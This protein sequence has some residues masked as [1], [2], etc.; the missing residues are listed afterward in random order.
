MISIIPITGLPEV[1]A[2]D[3]L[4][5]VITDGIER[6]EVTPVDGDIF[7]VTHKVVSKAE[8]RT[9]RVLSD[10]EYRTVV[11]AEAATIVRKRGDLV[12]TRTRHGFVCANAG[13]DRSNAPEG[14]AI[15]L[16]EDPDKSAHRL[17]R[18]LE[19]AYG[20]RVGVLIT[21]T[22]GRAWRGGQVDLAIGI[23]GVVSIA[24]LRGSPDSDGRTLTATQIA[25]ADELAAAAD[26]AMGKSTAI[27]V[28]VVRG[29]NFLGE[30]RGSDLV[31]DPAEDLFL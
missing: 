29:G 16:P 27:P 14:T 15:M 26:L 24:D 4:I 2:G 22:F 11:E 20:C 6:N 23:S 9:V 31:R 8:G 1:S 3:D 28:A 18:A 30:G 12:I 5:A 21:D 19:Q 7:V 25:V 10:Q 17:R 13:V